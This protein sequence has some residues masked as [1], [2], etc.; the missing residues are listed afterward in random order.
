LF[1]VL[2]FSFSR[3]FSCFLSYYDYYYYYYY[4]MNHLLRLTL[5][6]LACSVVVVDV[7]ALQ[8]KQ[9]FRTGVGSTS[10]TF[11]QGT[12]LGTPAASAASNRITV[13]FTE[14]D[15]VRDP[16]LY[17]ENFV[18]FQT[19]MLDSSLRVA[20]VTC[21]LR[22]NVSSTTWVARLRS[23]IPTFVMP[24]TLTF[25]SD[26]TL[27]AQEWSSAL[28]DDELV[29]ES[30]STHAVASQAV[31]AAFHAHI[32]RVERQ[33]RD[34]GAF[35]HATDDAAEHVARRLLQ[36]VDATPLSSED[37]A[38][39]INRATQSIKAAANLTTSKNSASSQATAALSDEL[40]H[41][42]DAVKGLEAMLNASRSAQ[43]LNSHDLNAGYATFNK[44]WSD[45]A[46]ALN[47][48]LN[49]TLA[50]LRVQQQRSA[51]LF[52]DAQASV[53]GALGELGRIGGLLNDRRD[54]YVSHLTAIA[55]SMQ[56]QLRQQDNVQSSIDASLSD[57]QAHL[58]RV[59][60]AYSN[61]DLRWRLASGIGTGV[62]P[63][64][65]VTLLRAMSAYGLDLFTSLNRPT[66]ATTLL[67]GLSPFFFQFNLLWNEFVDTAAPGEAYDA[68]VGAR[69][70]DILT[71]PGFTAAKGKYA[72]TMPG[73]VGST[74]R[75]YAHLRSVGIACAPQVYID[76]QDVTVTTQQAQGMIGPAGCTPGA[77]CR[78]WALV[79]RDRC[80]VYHPTA[81]P[82]GVVPVS[83]GFGGDPARVR[84][85]YLDAGANDAE[86]ARGLRAFPGLVCGDTDT[87]QPW[88]RPTTWDTCAYL[89]VNGAYAD[90]TTRPTSAAA[91]A[92]AAH[93]FSCEI[94]TDVAVL[95]AELAQTCARTVAD[96]AASTVDAFVAQ[97]TQVPR[98]TGVA[99]AI[100]SSA[101]ARTRCST[102]AQVCE[103]QSNLPGA[104][105]TLSRAYYRVQLLAL[106]AYV[107]LA[108][109]AHELVQY[110]YVPEHGHNVHVPYVVRG[111]FRAPNLTRYE[112]DF[113]A[114]LIG[115]AWQQPVRLARADV[116]TFASLAQA[117]FVPVYQLVR[118]ER[119]QD[120]ALTCTFPDG[121][122]V[123]QVPE[124]VDVQSGYADGA[125]V[126]PTSMDYVGWLEALRLPERT[127]IFA[128]RASRHLYAV[129][130][131][132][133]GPEG[134]ADTR[135]HRVD[136]LR[137]SK[138]CLL[139]RARRADPA[140]GTSADVQ[141]YNSMLPIPGAGGFNPLRRPLTV[142]EWLETE[143]LATFDASGVLDSA[144][145]YHHELHLG[146][147]DFLR[148]QAMPGAEA[149]DAV[150]ADALQYN[151]WAGMLGPIPVR[152]N[153]TVFE[154]RG[155]PPPTICRYL[156]THAPVSLRV[157]GQPTASL[158]RVDWDRAGAIQFADATFRT[159]V[160][161]T[162][163]AGLVG[164]ANV[165]ASC[166]AA[167]YIQILPSSDAGS[168]HVNVV[169]DKAYDVLLL[170]DFQTRVYN[171]SLTQAEMDAAT[172]RAACPS[173]AT[174]AQA[175]THEAVS[176]PLSLQGTT[177]ATGA[178][179]T[180]PCNYVRVRVR[181]R[182]TDA[183]LASLNITLVP[184]AAADAAT[185]PSDDPS[186]PPEARIATCDTW[187]GDL[188]AELAR[189]AAARIGDTRTD[190]DASIRSAGGNSEAALYASL[191]NV[192]ASMARD[193][194]NAAR[195]RTANAF[196]ALQAAL[197]VQTSLQVDL[198]RN[199][200]AY[201]LSL[202][203]GDAPDP[204][205]IAGMRAQV[206]QLAA[207]RAQ[208]SG[209]V[210][211]VAA[212]SL[213]TDA[214]VNG[215]LDDASAALYAFA[216]G[217][218]DKRQRDA[219]DTAAFFA[220]QRLQVD[221]LI[222]ASSTN[223]AEL[224]RVGAELDAQTS[225][226][227]ATG[228]ITERAPPSIRDT[229]LPVSMTITMPSML[230]ALET[231]LP[232]L[233][234]AIGAAA[235]AALTGLLTGLEAVIKLAKNLFCDL[236]PLPL[237]CTGINWF[238]VVLIVVVLIVA[239]CFVKPFVAAMAARAAHGR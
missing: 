232:R 116:T 61:R 82:V 179:A 114:G 57:L 115:G 171:A 12:E 32:M 163:N 101:V 18:A 135:R 164:D 83:F 46:A 67:G 98:A 89:D 152:C 111:H 66:Q 65:N 217:L 20:D 124:K 169:N 208:L 221:A 112:A 236:A 27:A 37:F 123:T 148:L 44:T 201:A 11:A 7:D 209:F 143:A 177:A 202:P 52:T 133:L 80:Q 130:P 193:S 81:S 125:N 97:M 234:S 159:T 33:A 22:F 68:D 15:G 205:V 233:L 211:S 150:S 47:A 134:P 126:E 100:A 184:V 53:D 183:Y 118:Q 147:A 56:Y 166:P 99:F 162:T 1:G 76:F 49:A 36:V 196:E 77:T 160:V 94:V 187:E 207:Q 136:Y 139:R 167:Q 174:R 106:H 215:S 176:L 198:V 39:Q 127:N 91:D 31:V 73:M 191:G 87:T 8:V 120:V 71:Q 157:P 181:A 117:H 74:L 200:S 214:R 110:G 60:D 165:R 54:F 128:A 63:A 155:V 222:N 212:L 122:Q 69:V 229:P 185:A 129:P 223:L 199:M 48:T 10:A 227:L 109:R 206:S 28:V 119:T 197:Q 30:P 108:A 13:T 35:G 72:R 92:S 96:A 142:E 50:M 158:D 34:A 216:R 141:F 45:N 107:A 230:D 19:R 225:L 79:K 86:L 192:E 194:T 239:V 113:R 151:R 84:A 102:D 132:A 156:E 104:N 138:A 170:V 6:F 5:L 59:S 235:Q 224:F 190:V 189:A 93:R 4:T 21:S 149:G 75:T 228:R 218:L 62:R 24:Q 204:T 23:Y 55:G 213:A 51:Q 182:A 88:F 41:I 58:K 188:G 226:T 38:N 105:E 173:H 64:S 195:V 178:G 237:V 220:Q 40:A 42:N 140:R 70:A 161:F 26:R 95:H 180:N 172:T 25:T 103:M 16:R 121:S 2:F 146:D 137:C 154:A 14:Q 29:D 175:G 9:E 144:H 17:A 238:V 78:C 231:I 131:A 203:A 168:A 90:A 153:L 3:S 145:A 43:V 210:Q 85:T 186:V 219:N